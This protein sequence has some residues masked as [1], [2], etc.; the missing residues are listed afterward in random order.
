MVNVYFITIIVHERSVVLSWTAAPNPHA[1]WSRFV[2]AWGMFVDGETRAEK[3][4][5]LK[6][7]DFARLLKQPIASCEG[8]G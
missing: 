8:V 3:I 7:R 1:A 2:K 4:A 5:A 6:K